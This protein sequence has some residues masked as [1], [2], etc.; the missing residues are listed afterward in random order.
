MKTP[1]FTHSPDTL[2]LL[3]R[4]L[5][6]A[7]GGEKFGLDL[8]QFHI[9]LERISA[10]YLPAASGAADVCTFYKSLRVE[11]LALARACAAG[12]E[13]AWNAF[14]SR[15]R[16]KLYDMALHIAKESSAARD[17]ADS[18]YADLYGMSRR[19]GK[20]VCKLASYAGRGS[21]EGWLRTVMAQEFV[22]RYRKQRRLV[23]LDEENEEGIQFAAVESERSP[24]IDPRLEA[25]V[26]AAL[27]ALA[28]EDR[29]VLASYFLDEH[30]LAQIARTLGVHESTIS[31]KVDKLTKS[32]RK[33]M[34][35]EMVR[36]GMSR[37][38]AKEALEADVRE[39]TL[40]IREH[41]APAHAQ[42][43]ARQA[44][45]EKEVKARTSEGPA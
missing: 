1:S 35:A 19:D 18:V 7:S 14:L 30:T 22:N 27:T 15:Y 4:E 6:L 29:F 31:R 33:Q 45:P 34:V 36:H 26:G 20:R 40:N 13:A 16:E 25:A 5:H 9:I 8:E 39:L 11:E 12:D 3:I 43:S 41:L 28:A 10:K 32:L 42:E 44:F 38:Q 2:R 23:S 37:R 17:L 24:S 21:L